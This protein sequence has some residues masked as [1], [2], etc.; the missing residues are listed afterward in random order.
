M[1]QTVHMES[2]SEPPNALQI[3]FPLFFLI[4]VFHWRK[5]EPQIS[6][7][8]KL[9]SSPKDLYGKIISAKKTKK[10]NEFGILQME[11]QWVWTLGNKTEI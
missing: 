2:F 11:S 10:P 9:L 7:F 4:K 5:P 1:N 8:L 3:V 6:V